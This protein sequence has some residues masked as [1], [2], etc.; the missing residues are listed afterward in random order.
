MYQ[1][2]AAE[3][4]VY[5]LLRKKPNPVRQG[6]NGPFVFIHIN[7]NAGTS[8]GRAVGL[9][10]K[11]HLTAREV[12]ARVGKDKWNDAFKF[13]LVRNP[14]DKAVSLYEYRKK[15]DRTGIASRNIEFQIG[16]AHV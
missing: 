14:W 10:V 7:K 11:D 8:I 9:P 15:K 13:T 6:K 12:I 1:G 3:K 2:T 5:K 4:W 16:R